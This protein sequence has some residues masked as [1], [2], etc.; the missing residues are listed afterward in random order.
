METLGCGDFCCL[1]MSS[2]VQRWRCNLPIH[3]P[4]VLP[5]DLFL[6]L[7]GVVVANV[8]LPPDLLNTQHLDLLGDGLAT[9]Q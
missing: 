2:A 8:E 3:A 7:F 1:V 5:P 6:L 9:S 4:L